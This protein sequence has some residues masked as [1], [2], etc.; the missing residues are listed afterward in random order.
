MSDLV[1]NTFA[2]ARAAPKT[3]SITAGNGSAVQGADFACAIGAYVSLA[4]GASHKVRV[5]DSTVTTTTGLEL[6]PGDVVFLPVA[7]LNHLYAISED[8]ATQQVDVTA[9]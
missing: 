3:T 6:S 2:A 1:R 4:A 7:N 9:F 5:G 8:A